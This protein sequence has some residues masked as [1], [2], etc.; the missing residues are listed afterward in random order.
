MLRKKLVSV[1]DLAKR[2]FRFIPL[3]R[4]EAIRFHGV[5]YAVR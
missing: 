5:N 4:V 2:R 1:Y 3:E